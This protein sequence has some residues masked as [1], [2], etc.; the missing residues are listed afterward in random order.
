ML[1]A[2]IAIV[3][4]IVGGVLGYYFRS[5]LQDQAEAHDRKMALFSLKVDEM[6]RIGEFA[7]RIPLAL[8]EARSAVLRARDLERLQ[9]KDSPDATRARTQAVTA[10]NEVAN[11][12]GRLEFAFVTLSDQL[13][14]AYAGAFNAVRNSHLELVS[15]VRAAQELP[16]LQSVSDATTTLVKAM[17]AEVRGF[18]N[19]NPVIPTSS[20][21]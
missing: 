7:Q 20:E 16:D 15:A 8:D 1:S 11:D 21:E 13:G 18:E 14:R 17:K 12:I 3:S 5:R 9:G 6:K 10:L 4:A 19:G 2:L